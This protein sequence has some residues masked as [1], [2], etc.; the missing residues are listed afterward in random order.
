MAKVYSVRKPLKSNYTNNADYNENS[1]EILSAFNGQMAQEQMPYS[2]INGPAKTADGVINQN[3]DS[4]PDGSSTNT[5]GVIQQTQAYFITETDI[6]DFTWDRD[7]NAIS[8]VAILG[9]PSVQFNQTGG[10]TSWNKGIVQLSEYMDNAFMRIPTKEGM[11]KGH[12]LVDIEYYFVGTKADGFSGNFGGDWRYQLYVFVNGEMVSTTGPFAGG[13][14]S[15]YCLN[16]AI[17]VGTS[18]STEISIGMSATFNTEGQFLSIGPA[19]VN[20]YNVVL[21]AR[22]EYR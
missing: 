16:Y 9:P 3:Y 4:K 17:P 11:I 2:A 6:T 12:A 10:S 21:W 1:S 13:T 5:T 15:T 22:N 14:R 7:Q 19:Q 18:P 8:P 20:I